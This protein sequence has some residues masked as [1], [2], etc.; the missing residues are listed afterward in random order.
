[1]KL[2]SCNAA[3][4]LFVNRSMQT[5][6][7]NLM[8]I[9]PLSE[10][11]KTAL[12]R[13]LSD[14]D[15]DIFRSIRLVLLNC[16]MEVRSF[17]RVGLD[18]D[19][20][21][22]RQRSWKLISLLDRKTADADFISF[23]KRGGENLNLEKGAWSLVKTTFPHI[24]QDSYQKILDGYAER[25]RKDCDPQQSFPA[26]LMAINRIFFYEEGFL[27]DKKNY[28]D[29][30]NSYLNRVIDRK[31]GNPISL[32]LLYLFIAR[33]LSL[34][35]VGV[36]IPGHF[37][38]RLQS[39]TFNIFVD[40]FNMGNFLTQSQCEERLKR[41]GFGFESDFLSPVSP[42]RVLLR[43]CS[44]LHQIYQKAQR[45]SERD[46]IQKYLINLAN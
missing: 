19:D 7:A 26:T 27:G 18:S 44:N 33:R 38:L 20:R 14:P 40:P 4:Q 25:V 34:P 28:Y 39:S 8:D 41:C 36:A 22:V 13:L 5:E 12:V 6:L 24:D 11:D 31:L 45:L 15:P 3:V 32:C 17:L 42:R 21:L 16:G 23:C 10:E 9:G 29:P 43:I 2:I 1:M 46:R 35:L 30:Q 37:I